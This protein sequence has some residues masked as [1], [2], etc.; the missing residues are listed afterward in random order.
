MGLADTLRNAGTTIIA[1]LGDVP[2]DI[3]YYSVTTGA[4]DPVT[5]VLTK[6]ETLISL[7]GIKY[8]SKVETK[9]KTNTDLIQTKILIAGE[10]FGTTEPKE[11]DYMVID[12]V[13]YEITGIYPAPSEAVYVFIVRAV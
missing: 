6:T 5:D 2:K 4:Y 3:S 11:D 12:S 13:K 10:A 8:K 1:A 7:K 9:D